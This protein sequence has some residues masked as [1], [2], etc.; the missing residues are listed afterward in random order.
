MALNIIVWFSEFPELGH[1]CL[2]FKKINQKI[3]QFVYNMVSIVL[4]QKFFYSWL[5]KTFG[6]RKRDYPSFWL[7]LWILPHKEYGWIKYSLRNREPK[8]TSGSQQ[9]YIQACIINCVMI[10]TILLFIRHN[11]EKCQFFFVYLSPA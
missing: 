8:M 7:T 9:L 4:H 11:F 2:T 3:P 1:F 10:P 6:E 5:S